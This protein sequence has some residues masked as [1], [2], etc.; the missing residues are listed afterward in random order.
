MGVDSPDPATSAAG[1]ATPMAGHAAAAVPPRILTRTLAMVFLSSFGAGTSFSLLLS[2][3][4]LYASSIGAGG[5][6]AGLT[7]SVL[8][9]ST[10]AA[11][12]CAPRLTSRF[13]YR[14]VM[15]AGL[16]LLGIPALALPGSASTATVMAVCVLRGA[17]FAITAVL[18]GA[19]VAALV[20]PERR[21]EGLGLHGVVV[22]VPAVI[23]LPL[24]VWLAE[25]IGY[26]SVFTA[27]A[28]AALAGLAAVP[29]LPGRM[30]RPGSRTRVL[31]PLGILAGLRTP[32]LVRP[33]IVFSAAA[34]AAGIVATFL[35]VALAPGFGDLA[36]AALLAQAAA[37]TLARW[38]A[39]RHADKNDTGRLLAP[40]ALLTAAGVA[41]PALTTDP[42]A[43]V[44]GMALF[45]AGFGVAQ[46]ASLM[47]MFERAPAS[48]YG[49]VSAVWNL[50]YDAGM[51]LGAAA[52]GVLAARTGYPAAFALTAAL[53]PIA[54]VF[55][56]SPRSAR[57][58][59][60]V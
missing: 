19:L 45:G 17:G 33:S 30:P 44:A 49:T 16:V 39:G 29:A 12:L 51:G 36:A 41:V 37:S 60:R 46:N 9:A 11:E 35:P 10:V 42:V 43:V 38:W 26:A 4:P 58:G 20:P 53:I 34:M 6:G 14:A 59:G 52:F 27:G 8:M 21:G 1:P 25:R 40:G 5:M 47:L 28:L 31:Q 50:A 48:T 22:G 55:A 7:T 57:G 18:S 32:A 15:A 23:A 56:R 54:L 24:G 2:V 13:G 3:V